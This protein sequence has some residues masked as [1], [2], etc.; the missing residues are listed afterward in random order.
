[1]SSWLPQLKSLGTLAAQR[2]CKRVILFG[3]IQD[4]RVS[5]VVGNAELIWYRVNLTIATCTLK[6]PVDRAV[7]AY[8]DGFT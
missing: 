5:Y 3:T 6:G 1:M 8:G 4:L 7:N 2:C